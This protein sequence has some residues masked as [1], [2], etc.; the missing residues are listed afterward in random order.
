M[1]EKADRRACSDVRDVAKRSAPKNGAQIAKPSEEGAIYEMLPCLV[2]KR[3]PA[4]PSHTAPFSH[5]PRQIALSPR[6]G[7]PVAA[8]C[9]T[10]SR[11]VAARRATYQ[12][13][14]TCSRPP[15]RTHAPKTAQIP[16]QSPLHCTPKTSPQKGPQKAPQKAQSK[17]L[18]YTALHQ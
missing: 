15:A 13:P 4:N 10:P 17:Y 2:T 14:R 18:S 8:H 11:H 12:A 9:S 7:P 6:E 3:P 16:T 5:R 1:G